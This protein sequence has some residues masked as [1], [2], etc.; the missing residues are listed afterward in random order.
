MEETLVLLRERDALTMWRGNGEIQE[1][2]VCDSFNQLRC[3]IYKEMNC[4]LKLLVS[5]HQL[6]MEFRSF[7][8]NYS[9]SDEAVQM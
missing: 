3:L 8:D 7:V 6:Q 9:C 5:L 4:T 2:L 1:F